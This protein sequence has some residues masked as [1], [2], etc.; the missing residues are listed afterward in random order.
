V[1]ISPI[2]VAVFIIWAVITTILYLTF[3][4]IFATFNFVEWGSFG[5]AWFILLDFM[6]MCPYAI[7]AKKVWCNSTTA[8][9]KEYEKK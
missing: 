2:L 4:F 1:K 8:E 3:S 6:L 9:R 7:T 5:R